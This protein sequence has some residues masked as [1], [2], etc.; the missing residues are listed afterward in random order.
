MAELTAP[1]GTSIGITR[2]GKP[3]AAE[4][5]LLGPLANLNGTWFGSRGWEMIAVPHFQSG[6][7]AFHLIIRPY[8]EVINFRPIG[9]QVPDRGATDDLFITGLMYDMRIT[10]ALSNEPLHLEAG[11]WFYMPNQDQQ[12]ARSATIPHGD[13]LL[14]LGTATTIDGPPTF[15]EVSGVPDVH[16]PPLGYLDPYLNPDSGPFKPGDVNATLRDDIAGH[17]I[18]STDVLD[19]STQSTGGILNIPFVTKNANATAFT[20]T[21]WIETVET[22]DPDNPIVQLQYTQTTNIEFIE[23]P[24]KSGL[25]MWPHVNVNTLRKQ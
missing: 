11:M 17:T 12:I 18:L 16:D 2:L 14:A 1:G 13:A 19:I 8:I 25:I 23:Q 22:D 4:A 9:A 7:D 6:P 20:G 21:Y 10:D 3:A 15:E 24:D 5:D